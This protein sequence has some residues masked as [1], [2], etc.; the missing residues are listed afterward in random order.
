MHRRYVIFHFSFCS[1]R[2]RF[3]RTRVGA[4]CTKIDKAQST[5][6]RASHVAKAKDV[7]R[8]SAQQNESSKD[9]CHGVQGRSEISSYG[10]WDERASTPF[11]AFHYVAR[12]TAVTIG[13]RVLCG[14]SSKLVA[15]LGARNPELGDSEGAL[16]CV[17][18]QR[19]STPASPQSSEGGQ[20]GRDSRP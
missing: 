14:S 16:Y 12:P 17:G 9:D 5:S 4:L 19:Q 15:S 2:H 8:G 10:Q 13:Q 20:S 3:P 18:K 11:E 1:S 6:S 7:H